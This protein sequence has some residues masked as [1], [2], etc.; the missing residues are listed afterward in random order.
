M[1]W[2][3]NVYLTQFRQGT[4]RILWEG[5]M[6]YLIIHG[7]RGTEG[8]LVLRGGQRGVLDGECSP[9]TQSLWVPIEAQVMYHL[10]S[11]LALKHMN[12]QGKCLHNW[13]SPVGWCLRPCSP[14]LGARAILHQT[15]PWQWREDF[16]C[17]SPLFCTMEAGNVIWNLRRP[18]VDGS[19]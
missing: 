17:L 8:N 12:K 9:R 7:E 1:R 4:T 3:K 14:G 15:W 16:W 5:D 11:L 2:T 19:V 6:D 10:T 13:R 18:R